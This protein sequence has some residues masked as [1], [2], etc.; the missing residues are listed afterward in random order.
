MLGQVI[1]PGGEQGDLDV[2]GAGVLLVHFVLG[3][4]FGFGYRHGLVW[5]ARLEGAWEAPRHPPLATGRRPVAPF[6][7]GEPGSVMVA[8]RNR[9]AVTN[10]RAHYPWRCGV[11]Q[12][13]FHAP[14]A[15]EN[16][17]LS[18]WFRVEG[19]QQQP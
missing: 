13:N 15:R 8:A 17:V 18:S 19:S 3:D 5:V 1:D 10:A 6:N 11:A 4:D 16:R 14:V 7:P 12:A 2:A 9:R